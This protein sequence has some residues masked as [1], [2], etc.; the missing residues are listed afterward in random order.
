MIDE[1]TQEASERSPKHAELRKKIGW[2]CQTLRFAVLVYAVWTLALN[3]IYWSDVAAIESGYGRLLQKDLSG[4]QPW[5]QASAFAVSFVVWLFAAYACYCGWRLFSSYLKGG[6]FSLES[7]LW[8]RRL[9]L[10]GATAQ[11]LAIAVR[12]LISVLLTLHFPAGQKLRVINIFLLPND[13]LTLVLLLGFLALA[14]IQK[15]AAEIADD[16]AQIV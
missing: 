10:Y 16:H 3:V 14:H 8:L 11:A 7:A 12:P 4:L 15:S 13:M 6:I 9:A 2:I 1:I 5:Q